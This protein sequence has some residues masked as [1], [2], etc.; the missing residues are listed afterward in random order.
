MT[1]SF[2]ARAVNFWITIIDGAIKAEKRELAL[3]W[4]A[5]KYFIIAL[6]RYGKVLSLVEPSHR[7]QILKSNL[8]LFHPSPFLRR[9]YHNVLRVNFASTEQQLFFP[10]EQL[11]PSS[12]YARLEGLFPSLFLSLSFY[13]FEWRTTCQSN[14]ALIV[15]CQH[16]RT[17]H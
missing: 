11:F 8:E 6:E 4:F 16:A 3:A 2:S 12:H 13:T 10:A 9:T 1:S 15:A 7:R 17:N 14:F 5:S